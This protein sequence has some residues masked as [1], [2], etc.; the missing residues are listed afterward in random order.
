MMPSPKLVT[1]SIQG[2]SSSPFLRPCLYS[3]VPLLRFRYRASLSREQVDELVRP[4]PETVELV[5]TWLTHHRIRSSSISR[6]HGC[7]WLTVSDLRVSHASQLL[8]ASYHL[9]WNMKTNET[10][11]RTVGYS[12]P[13]YT[14]SICHADDTFILHGGDGAD[15]T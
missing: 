6:I 15:T 7:T 5:Y 4:S 12:L 11:I 3:L 8:G 2:T 13:A 9:Y 10:I 14:R 1:P